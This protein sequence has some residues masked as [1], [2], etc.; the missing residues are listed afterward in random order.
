MRIHIKLTAFICLIF[1]VLLLSSCASRPIKSSAE[2]SEIVATCDGHDIPY[3]QVRY[4]VLSHKAE[5]ASAYG[6]DIW[7]DPTLA[8]QYKDE[9]ISRVEND[10]KT[11]S[12]ILSVGK[13]YNVSI[14][15]KEI[16]E[17]VQS[18]ID[19]VVSEIYKGRS[20]YKK[21]LAEGGMTDSFLRFMY[22][23]YYCQNELYIIMTEHLGAISVPS[24]E[25]ELY[26]LLCSELYRTTHVYIPCN[27]G[28]N[29][30]EANR[31]NAE[32]IRE[33]I[34]SGAITF[35]DAQF[36]GGT[37]TTLASDGN[38]FTKGYAEKI[39]EDAALSLGKGEISPVIEMGGAFYIIKRLPLDTEYVLLNLYTFKA[40]YVQTQF[41]NTLSDYKQNISVTY[42]KD[43]DFV[44]IK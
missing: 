6:E 13:N 43:I 24:D 17:A 18:E 39:Y 30:K 3:E 15:D 28:G 14:D 44:A 10:I 25:G 1:A 16:Q 5:L 32:K 4:L 36:L 9:L 2:D 31:K 21:A 19:Y 8:A 29:D 37:D 26:D 12:T 42:L 11:Y 27:Y 23:I 35:E 20:E 34:V 7:D 41:N 22:G 40:Q 38:Y 33:D